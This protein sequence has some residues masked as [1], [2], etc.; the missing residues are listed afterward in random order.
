KSYF[1]IGLVLVSSLFVVQNIVIILF[2]TKL[3]MAGPSIKS[4]VETAAPYL[5]VI[6]AAQSVALSVLLWI[7][8][9]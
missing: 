1:T 5:L 9:K 6:N 7:T 4:M 3:F 2:W 8:R